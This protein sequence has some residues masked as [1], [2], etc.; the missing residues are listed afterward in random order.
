MTLSKELDFWGLQL[1][2]LLNRYKGFLYL[3]L[4][5]Q[6]TQRLDTEEL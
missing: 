4:E 6:T 1:S 2:Q 3:L 5:G